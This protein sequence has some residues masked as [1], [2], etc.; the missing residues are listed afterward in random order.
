ME[1]DFAIIQNIAAPKAFYTFKDKYFLVRGGSFK[2]HPAKYGQY[3]TMA[4]TLVDKVFFRKKTYSF[5]EKYIFDRCYQAKPKATKGGSPG[6][7]LKATLCTHM[8][9]VFQSI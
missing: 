3:F 6:S 2:T 8:T 5:G 7:W 1:M 4:D 9:F